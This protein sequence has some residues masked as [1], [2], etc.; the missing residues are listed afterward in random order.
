MTTISLTQNANGTPALPVWLPKVATVVVLIAGV[1]QQ[2]DV[3]PAGSP[4]LRAL[5]FI[6]TV[7]AAL[8]IS[9]QGWR[10]AQ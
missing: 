3:F 5:N 4:W 7:G 2:A 9:S 1:L 10:R 6:I 8:G